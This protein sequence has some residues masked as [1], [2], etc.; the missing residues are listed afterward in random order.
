MSEES[1]VTCIPD[2]AS[3]MLA[4]IDPLDGT[5]NFSRGIPLYSVSIALLKSG[6][7]SVSVVRHVSTG[8]IYAALKGKGA[9]KISNSKWFRLIRRKQTL[10]QAILS[11][12]CNMG[13]AASRAKWIEWQR[14]LLPP[15]CFRLRLIES[16]SLELCWV[17]EGLTDGY[18]HPTDQP[19]DMCAGGLIVS[20]TGGIVLGPDGDIW[21]PLRRGIVAVAPGLRVDI[22]RILGLVQE[23]QINTD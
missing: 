8:V 19:W 9:W 21:R 5:T 20:E 11:L 15:V 16:A 3:P 1:R 18:I 17:A 23:K 14:L 12:S 22:E 4:V 2:P 7:P 13:D 6:S 10:K